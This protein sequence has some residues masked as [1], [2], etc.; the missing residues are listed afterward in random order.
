MELD[1]YGKSSVLFLALFTGTTVLILIVLVS[2]R[3]I[4]T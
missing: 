1:F 3:A 4:L 2:I